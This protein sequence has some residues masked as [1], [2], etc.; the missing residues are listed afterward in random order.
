MQMSYNIDKCHTLH[1]GN[2]NKKHQYTLPKMSEVKH[3]TNST[4]YTYTFHNLTQVQEEKDL[5]VV[6]D[7]DLKFRKHISEK[8]S[9][10]NSILY[11]IKHTF[12][13]LDADMFNLLYKSLVRPHLEYASS[14][15]SPT[16]KGD[17]QNLEKVQRR[18]TKLVPGISALPYEDRLKQLHLP[19]L[20]YRRLRTD[21]ILIY[22]YTNHLITLDPNTRCSRCNNISMLPASPSLHTRGHN[23]KFQVQHHPG[24]R[25]RF[26]T[27]RCIPTWNNLNHNT[28]NAKS[29]N[30][31]KNLSI[32]LSMPNKYD[33]T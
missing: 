19:T 9:K 15:W 3:T 11:L 5:G 12:K 22:K 26:L 23:Q 24:I 29:I 30:H 25:N 7:A 6:I 1:L 16:L 8:V 28:V 21:L 10:A 4:A 31:F 20:Q 17:I 14:V 2:H 18:A 27:S 13:Y 33:L 32:N